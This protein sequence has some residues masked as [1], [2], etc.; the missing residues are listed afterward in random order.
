MRCGR[1]LRA[2]ESDV[3]LDGFELP[4]LDTRFLVITAK[5]I[6]GENAINIMGTKVPLLAESYISYVGQPLLVLFGPDYESTELALEKIKV[7]TVPFGENEEKPEEPPTTEPLTFSWSSDNPEEDKKEKQEG[8]KVETSLSVIPSDIRK[9]VRH[10]ILTWTENNGSVHTQCPAQWAELVKKT[11]A[12]STLTNQEYVTVHPEKYLS[13]YDEF[14]LTPALYGAFTAIASI[15]TKLPAEMKIDSLGRRPKIDFSVTT[16]LNGENR[17]RHEEISVTVDGGAY[18]LNGR[19][20]QRQIMADIVPRYSLE[21]FKVEITN[22][23][24]HTI[25]TLFSGSSIHSSTQSFIALHN[26]RLAERSLVTPLKH[27]LTTM[28]ESTKFTDWVPKH[29]LTDLGEKMKSV[30][31]DSDYE[32]KWSAGS[33]HAGDFGLQG[34]LYGIGLS[35]GLSVS[36]LSTTC[37]RENQFQAQISYTA[38]KNI[39]IRGAV[40]A[41]VSEDKTLK[42]LISQFFNRGTVPV[43]FQENNLRGYDSG[44]DILYTYQTTFLTQLM[45]AANKLS[46]LIGEDD[47]PIDLNFNAQN[48]TLPCEFEASGYGA[49]VCEINIPKVSLEPVAKKL[50]LDVALALPYTRGV[51]RKIKS[52]AT[53]TLAALGARLDDNFSISVKFSS[54][55]KD[56]N[57]YSS[58]ENATRF[59]VT[60]SYVAALWQALGEKQSLIAPPGAREIDAILQGGQDR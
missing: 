32:R 31:T 41:S 33:L 51:Q 21:S 9:Y 14:L 8:R 23:S 16:W 53:E 50:W 42:D 38:K 59:L 13:H 47:G 39:T 1:L 17:P 48:L 29:D 56:A 12:S 24:S 34:Y 7:I 3:R 60:S 37:A 10:N 46:T 27:Y 58:L 43:I 11:I 5:D 15:K 25:P 36:G 19:E 44:P 40:P 54:E 2:T 28:R 22:V 26:S 49:A 45:K 4:Q 18:S 20:I 6:P 52:I 30:A 57:V 35:S 55:K